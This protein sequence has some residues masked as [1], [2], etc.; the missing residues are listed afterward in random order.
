MQGVGGFLR[1]AMEL[2]VTM[3]AKPVGRKNV[4][5]RFPH[6]NPVFRRNTG[7]TLR[8]KRVPFRTVT[9]TESESCAVPAARRLGR[10]RQVVDADVPCR[11]PPA[12]CL[13]GLPV[14]ETRI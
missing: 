7:K 13:L 6:S 9:T 3:Q 10:H 4:A 11:Q 12:P 2:Q 1:V 5:R 8:K 14:R